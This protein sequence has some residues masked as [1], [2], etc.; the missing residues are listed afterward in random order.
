MRPFLDFSLNA[1][2]LAGRGSPTKRSPTHFSSSFDDMSANMSV[3]KKNTESVPLTTRHLRSWDN[4]LSPPAKKR[5]LLQR[6][7]LQL[8]SKIESDDKQA[9]KRLE[10]I[11]V[12]Y[13]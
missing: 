8:V 12:Q 1:E 2:V 4:S 10:Q 13:N 6:R 3:T 5:Q 7:R 11:R 9:Q